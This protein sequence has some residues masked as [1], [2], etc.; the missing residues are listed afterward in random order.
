MLEWVTRHMAATR[1]TAHRIGW[2]IAALVAVACLA[3]AIIE[4]FGTAEDRLAR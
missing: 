2:T 4:S 1:M 3:V